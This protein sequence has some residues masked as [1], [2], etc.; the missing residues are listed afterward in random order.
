MSEANPLRGEVELQLGDRQLV[1]RPSFA[2]LVRAEEELGSL[3]ALVE[4]VAAGDVRLQEI[5]GLFWHCLTGDRGERQSFEEALLDAGI[6]NLLPIYRTL[7]AR[8]F[9]GR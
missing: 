3:L 8:L 6:S 7:L 5:G 4:R 9:G 1:L 2:A